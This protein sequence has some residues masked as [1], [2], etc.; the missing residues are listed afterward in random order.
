MSACSFYYVIIVKS[1]SCIPLCQNSHL[2]QTARP[3][4]A[5]ITPYYHLTRGMSYFSSP[6]S[7]LP[8]STLSHLH[9]GM[10][11]LERNSQQTSNKI[12]LYMGTYLHISPI[13][14]GILD[15]F[16]QCWFSVHNYLQELDKKFNANEKQESIVENPIILFPVLITSFSCSRSTC[17]M[18]F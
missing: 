18:N 13:S 8:P 11:S 5:D 14:P 7:S 10:V 1:I 3:K 16:V 9:V 15:H 4:V 2:K 17:Y 6:F 12:P